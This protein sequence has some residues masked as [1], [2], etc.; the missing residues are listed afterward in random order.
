MILISVVLFILCIDSGSEETA[1]KNVPSDSTG[2]GLLGRA[3]VCPSRP[4]SQK[5]HVSDYV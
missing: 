4:C 5:L 3:E 1:T 2:N